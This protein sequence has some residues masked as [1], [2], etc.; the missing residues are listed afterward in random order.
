MSLGT[1]GCQAIG[2]A[3]NSTDSSGST[4][5]PNDS[6]ITRCSRG[7]ACRDV[8]HVATAPHLFAAP[9]ARKENRFAQY[10]MATR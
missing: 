9:L 5:P 2:G 3:S 8:S 10:R 6:R 7:R 1:L 4:R